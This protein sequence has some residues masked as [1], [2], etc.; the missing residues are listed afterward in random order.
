VYRHRSSYLHALA[1]CTA[2]IFPGGLSDADVLLPVGPLFHVNSWG[3]PH[4]C[5]LSGAGLVL[6]DRFLDPPHLLALLAAQ[7]VT[8]AAGVPSVWSALLQV[9]DHAPHPLPG[10]RAILCGGSAAAPALISGFDRHGLR[11]VQAWGMTETSPLGT[12][13]V[14]KHQ[15]TARLGPDQLLRVRATQGLPAPGVELR[16]ADLAG[17]GPCPHDGQHAGALQVRGPWVCAAYLNSD[18]RSSF[19]PDGWL[20]SGDVATIDD[21]G[22][23]QTVDRTKDLVTSGGGEWISSVALEGLLMGHPAVLE[24]AVIGRPDTPLGRAPGGLH[25]PPAGAAG[26]P[27]RRGPACPSRAPRRMLLGAGR[28]PRRRRDPHDRGRQVRQAGPEGA[29]ARGHTRAVDPE[30]TAPLPAYA[31]RRWKLQSAAA[32]TTTSQA[33]TQAR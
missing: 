4:A 23:M 26:R 16:L 25:R 10:L 17:G 5:L 18:D 30:L 6:P 1:A 19:A 29:P 3:Q 8:I 15:L 20:R 2:S 28:V 12:V 31:S 14:V 24:A 27:Q 22:S 7:G 21:E 33:A 32:S 13:A 11:M 9:L